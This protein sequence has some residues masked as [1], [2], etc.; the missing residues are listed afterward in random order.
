MFFQL[1]A[2]PRKAKVK[3]IPNLPEAE[4]TQL[5]PQTDLLLSPAED[6]P[7]Q[8]QTTI[9]PQ[10]SLFP[11]TLVPEVQPL[12]RSTRRRLDVDATAVDEPRK[13]GRR[14]VEPT[15]ESV[16]ETTS[17]VSV[18]E[19]KDT[20]DDSAP[21]QRSRGDGEATVAELQQPLEDDDAQVSTGPP[22]IL[23]A[24]HEPPLQSYIQ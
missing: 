24:C 2:E 22:G 4:E 6:T 21:S 15:A 10:K 16:R 11:P 9:S 7:A 23:C 1:D 18:C 13:K 17:A 14:F 20:T 8:S 19:E 12:R 3:E 5:V